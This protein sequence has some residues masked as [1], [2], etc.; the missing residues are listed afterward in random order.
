M[1]PIKIYGRI[2][3]NK[4]I[5]FCDYSPCL[6]R[7]INNFRVAHTVHVIKGVCY[8]KFISLGFFTEL[9]AWDHIKFSVITTLN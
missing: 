9:L 6:D 2:K 1:E 8:I 3:K 7:A 5:Y 4:N